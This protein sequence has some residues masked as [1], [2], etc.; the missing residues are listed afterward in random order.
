EYF[1]TGSIAN[2]KEILDDMPRTLIELLEIPNLGPKTL[3]LLYDKF[4]IQTIDDLRN[5]I[6][7]Q[8]ILELPGM[9]QKRIEHIRQG[10]NLYIDKKTQHRIPLGIAITLVSQIVEYMRSLCEKISP[11]GSLRRMKETIG[12]IDILCASLHSSDVIQ[13][14]IEYPDTLN[15]LVKGDT[16]G[17]IIVKEKSL[18]VD[19][20]VVEPDS[21]GAALQY[22]TGS[23][24]HNIRLRLLAKEKGLKINE[25][26]VFKD[27][28]KIAGKTEE[29]VYHTFNMPV[30]PP[31]LR[32]DRGEIEAAL[33]GTL[34]DLIKEKDVLGDFHVHSN[35]SDGSNTIE[36]IANA[37]TSFGYKFIGI[38]DHSQ[39]SRFAG[40]MDAEKLAERNNI[41]DEVSKKF[42]KLRILKGA[43]VDILGDGSLDYPDEILSQ[44]DF[45][46]GSIHQ[47]FH[48]NVTERMIK[49]MK[50]PYLD[51]IGHPTGRL[52]SK[53][54]GYDV[55]I[56][57]VIEYAGKTGVALEIN[58]YFDRLD[59][60]DIN[61]L[62]AREKNVIF[63]IGSDSHNIN[64]LGN[65][66]LGV[67]VARR[68]WL[69]KKNLINCYDPVDLPLRRKRYRY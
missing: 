58:A 1:R 41:I 11:C 52:I 28:K 39:T 29:E 47:G 46:I 50:N 22:F 13:R 8:E 24:Q 10:L 43:E 30:I 4:K 65:M 56:D 32:E 57:R 63:A 38:T 40:G 16:K 34:P 54:E 55:D 61:V 53:R 19:L 59:L 64:M 25:Y 62:K 67:A 37:A 42:P 31:E 49:A 17:S 66:K 5:V 26:G 20:R 12:D 23:K 18:Q 51:I 69:V 45:V 68:G 6:N 15:V 36:E 35:F 48:K 3:K 27:D 60:N 14:F 7:S 44:L 33:K 2:Y 21:Y 9:G